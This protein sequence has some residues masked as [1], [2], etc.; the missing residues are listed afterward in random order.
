MKKI[1]KIIVVVLIYFIFSGNGCSKRV[2]NSLI[3]Y[4]SP[5]PII[6]EVVRDSVRKNKFFG[7]DFRYSRGDYDQEELSLLRLNYTYI[8]T[9]KNA[10]SNTSLMA[11]GGYYKVYGLGPK[12]GVNYTDINYNGIKWG[13]G[14]A[15]N[16]K[17]GLNLNFTNFKVGTGIDFL[18]GMETGEYLNFRNS[19]SKNGIIESQSGWIH[20]NFNWFIFSTYSFRNSSILNFQVHLG[21]P[22]RF[23][24]ILSYQYDENVYWIS[25]FGDRGN[26]GYMISLKKLFDGL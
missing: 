15:G 9:K 14:V 26:I 10:F 3:N 5:T 16:I 2:Y 20:A 17:I 11:F 13:G 19:A 24:P 21:Y 1:F 8:L 4:N 25:Y 6:Y 12:E 23:S 22:G 7:T 18:A